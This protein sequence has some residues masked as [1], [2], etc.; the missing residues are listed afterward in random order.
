[1]GRRLHTIFNLLHPDLSNKVEQKQ[2]K[3]PQ[4]HQ[5]VCI[6]C[7][8]GKIYA[9]NYSESHL[10]IPGIIVKVVTDPLSYHVETENGIDICRQQ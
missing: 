7:T 1:M 8:R 6:F 3:N 9:K 5:K 10:W 4:P 2:S